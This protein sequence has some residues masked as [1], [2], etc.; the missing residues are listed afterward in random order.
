MTDPAIPG[1]ARHYVTIGD[2]QL[3]YRRGGRGPALLLL[4]RLPRSG[5]DLVAAM[6]GLRDRFTVIAPDLAGYGNSWPLAGAAPEIGAYAEDIAAFARAVGIARCCVYGEGQGAAVAI[7]LAAAHPGLTAA[8]ALHGVAL[9]DPAAA[10]TLE[11][12]VPHW[13]GRH[14]SWLWAMLRE[15]CVFAPPNTKTLA[16]RIDAAL[17]SPADLQDRA[18]QFVSA[19]GQGRAY[20]LGLR[21]ALRF[22][23]RPALVRVEAPLLVCAARSHHEDAVVPQLP[24]GTPTAIRDD[25]AGARAAA[26][27]FLARYAASCPPPPAAPAAAPV[28]GRLWSDYVSVP[29]GQLHFQSNGDAATIP[30]LVQ[31]DAASSVGTVAPITAS[32]IGRR[33]VMAFDLP[34]SGDSDRT[35]D[36]T[37]EVQAYADTLAAALDRL[38]LGQVDFYGMWGGGFVGLEL[39]IARPALVRRLIMSN[40]FQHEGEERRRFQANYTPDVAPLWHGGHLLQCWHQM[41]DQG[42][43]Y[44]WFDRGRDGIIR[45][46]PFL[47]T[48]MV[49]ERVCSL[50]K[51]GNA[52]RTAYQAHFR[53]PTYARLRA[54]PVPTMIATAS[55]DPNNPDT[56]AAA[57]AAPNATF[58]LL[59]DDFMKWG[60]GFLDFLE[61]P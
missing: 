53:Y 16:A 14:L 23:P 19:P 35:L 40:L 34:G 59:D 33:T 43:Y 47:A 11:P 44:P 55:W 4:H 30:L 39:A 9:P 57:A 45:R 54:S 38:G 60:V 24:P 27:E 7:A 17:P 18:V 61:T 1:I 48:D 13:D 3:H 28:P 36:D 37:V 41:R 49:H 12:F 21:A 10:D 58:R 5:K 46:E 42:L 15:E 26:F 25:V 31:H 50:M 51:A 20:D 6:Q 29:G 8:V 56:K 32:F 52:Y 2:R 22:D